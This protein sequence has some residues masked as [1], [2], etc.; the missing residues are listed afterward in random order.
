MVF[1]KLLIFVVNVI[2]KKPYTELLISYHLHKPLQELYRTANVS[3]SRDPT[4]KSSRV[5]Y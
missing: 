5:F 3:Q 1:L 2:M 4:Q